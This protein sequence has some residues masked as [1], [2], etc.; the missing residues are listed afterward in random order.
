MHRGERVSCKQ[1]GSSFSTRDP[2]L[3][4]WLQCKCSAKPIVPTGSLNQAPAE[5]A[6]PPPNRS[7]QCPQRHPGLTHLGNKPIHHTH[8]MY[9]FRGL[10]YCNRC[11]YIATNQVRALSDRCVEP[12]RNGKNVLKHIRE[13]KVPP[14]TKL[15]KWPDEL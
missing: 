3:K 13:G 10:S 15:A 9:I 4:H 14:S 6:R 8:D 2:N 7:T 12:R 5:A 1:C 11:G